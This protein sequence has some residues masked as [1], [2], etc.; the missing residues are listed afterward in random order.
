MPEDTQESFN[1]LNGSRSGD[2]R[3]LLYQSAPKE[4]REVIKDIR[5]H[6]R[7]NN[8]EEIV[9]KHLEGHAKF[10]KAIEDNAVMTKQIVDN[11]SE[12]VTLFR[13]AKGVR[14]FVLWIWPFALALTAIAA[15]AM[16]YLK[17][18]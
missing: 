11:T 8:L 16:A 12:L 7:L 6:E 15:G 5:A 17:G 13:G 18:K 1:A 2:L 10:E 3:K 14:A 4:R 9:A